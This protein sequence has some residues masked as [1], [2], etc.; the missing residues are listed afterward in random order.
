MS[1]LGPTRLIVN[2]SFIIANFRFFFRLLV[3]AVRQVAADISPDY[4]G[5]TLSDS[6]FSIL[7]MDIPENH[8]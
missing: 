8:K 2:F 7:R 5:E 4:F 6:E 3:L 1:Y